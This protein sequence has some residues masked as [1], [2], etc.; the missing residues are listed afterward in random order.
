MNRIIGADV[1]TRTAFKKFI[2]KVFNLIMEAYETLKN[3]PQWSQM[4]YIQ[5]DIDGIKRMRDAYFEM[6]DGTVKDSGVKVNRDD[7][8]KE[9]KDEVV[10]NS[11]ARFSLKYF[12]KDGRR[13]VDVDQN[14][15]RFDGHD[16]S[17]YPRIA[18]DIIN[19]KF[20]GKVV[21]VDNKMFVNG[22]GRDEYAHSSKMITGELYEAKMRAA[23][24]IDNLLD[25]GTNFRNETDGRD[26]HIH[27]DAVGGF[28]YF[29]T[30]FKIFNK[31]FEGV[32][33]I[34]NTKRGK[35][36]KDVTKLKDVTE[37]IANSYGEDPAFGFLRT[38]SMAS[39]SQPEQESQGEFSSKTRPTDSAYLAAVKRGDME[40]AQK[41]VD[42]AAKEAG[43]D[44]PVLYH[45]TPDARKMNEYGSFIEGADFTVFDSSQ[46]FADK[47][48]GSAYFFASNRKTAEF[49]AP[50]VNEY[51]LSR[52]RKPKV[53]SVYLKMGKTFVVDANG[54]GWNNIPIS[55][56]VPMRKYRDYFTGEVITHKIANTTYFAKWA[57]NQG[58]DSVVL[59]NVI[60]G[61]SDYADLAG[62]VY[63][64][65]DNRNIKSADPVTYDDAGNVIPLSE[66]FNPKNEDI[67]FSKKTQPTNYR[68]DAEIL[69]SANGT[70]EAEKN[71]LSLYN[72]NRESLAQRTSNLLML[73]QQIETAK[74]KEKSALAAQIRRM[75]NDV[76][77]F[78]AR[79]NKL[80]EKKDSGVKVNR[81]DV[82][83]EIKAEVIEGG[84]FSN[85]SD[86]INRLLHTQIEL[87]KKTYERVYALAIKNN[88]SIMKD[89][90]IP[91][92]SYVIDGSTAYFYMNFDQYFELEY[93]EVSLIF[94]EQARVRSAK[95]EKTIRRIKEYDESADRIRVSAVGRQGE[96]KPIGKLQDGKITDKEKHRNGVHQNVQ[97]ASR[98]DGRGIPQEGNGDLLQAGGT[99]GA[100][101]RGGIKLSLKT[102][103]KTDSDY[104]SAV[105]RGDMETA[106][107]MVDEAAKE[108]GYD[109]PVLYHGTPDARKM[110]EYGSF[111]K[112]A[113]FTVFDSSQS[114]TDKIDGSAYFFAS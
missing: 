97:G 48:D 78:E 5:H 81:N 82:Y 87:P 9:I 26:G 20:V 46:S 103:A 80:R 38:S 68:T 94:V 19:E 106:Q 74:G 12:V 76:Q 102:T 51:S 31:Y 73:Q 101:R 37:D 70:T 107:N 58:Y 90:S 27:P 39:V 49:Y 104:L 89:G 93:D 91:K 59:Q 24:E 77:E 113:D 8:Y 28:D 42:Q 41:M 65:F 47:I 100:G 14:Q 45:S 75:E 43:Y 57:K 36:F 55:E 61:N 71:A 16:V 21:G 109:S 63:A 86:S 56:G 15:D 34:E 114:F 13:F 11:P 108:A 83:E 52:N 99:F 33:N 112:G 29:D 60:D 18:K 22:R 6:L 98:A 69:K 30:I 35:L 84:K 32:V 85:K 44:S 62:D 3:D 53:Y 92:L 96:N 79:M 2:D 105:N 95:C 17:E 1:D 23:G 111:I 7:V 25:A 110:N 64:I 67:R 4:Q 72:I 40:T 88:E 10:E 66:R 54:K 50:E